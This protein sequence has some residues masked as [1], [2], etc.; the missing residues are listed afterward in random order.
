MGGGGV[1]S[2]G[3]GIRDCPEG[4]GS[5][6]CVWQRSVHRMG[7]GGGQ[8]PASVGRRSPGAGAEAQQEAEAAL[9]ATGK[10]SSALLPAGPAQRHLALQRGKETGGPLGVVGS[11]MARLVALSLVP[12]LSR[13]GRLGD[14]ARERAMWPVHLV[15][16]GSPSPE[17]GAPQS[18]LLPASSPC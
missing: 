8:V 12:V 5:G 11:C 9:S 13:A 17:Q 6:A 16:H 1:E 18:F 14:T 4:R 10:A 2:G 7:M 3:P 15:W